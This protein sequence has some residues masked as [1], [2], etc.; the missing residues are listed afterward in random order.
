MFD[1][2]KLNPL[3]RAHLFSLSFVLVMTTSTCHTQAP[4]T[5]AQALQQHH[6]EITKAALIQALS[7]SGMPLISR[8]M[9]VF[10]L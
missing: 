5:F 1:H 4:P 9:H 2:L 10:Q 3:N 6:V 8:T 7:N